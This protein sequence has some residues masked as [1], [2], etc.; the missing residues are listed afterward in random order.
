MRC[1]N[2]H[3]SS[4]DG[5]QP[6]AEGEFNPAVVKGLLD[7]K[8][9]VPVEAEVSPAAKSDAQ[10]AEFD[11]AWAERERAHTAELDRAR[12]ALDAALVTAGAAETR[13]TALEVEVAQLKLDLEAAT[14]PK[15]AKG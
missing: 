6:G 12:A 9:L 2:D 8:L 3:T 10:R 11:A 4:I 14:A 1:R 13:A 7:A 15:K 5:V